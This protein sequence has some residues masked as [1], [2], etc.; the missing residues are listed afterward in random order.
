MARAKVGDRMSFPLRLTAA[1]VCGGGRVG[2]GGES[3]GGGGGGG[4]GKGKKKSGT[5]GGKE[6][7]GGE[8]K[9]AA[10]AD[11]DG[12]AYELAAIL[13]HKGASAHHGHYVAHVA[14]PARGRKE[15]KKKD[16]ENGGEFDW[17]RF[18]DEGVSALEGGPAGRAGA[19][20]HGVA[21]ASSAAAAAAA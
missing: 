1:E 11:E 5:G 19:A 4:K 18:D 21:A 2:E 20:D 10:A 6:E 15:G 9:D 17:W 16:G 7:A 3:G 12:A 14:L 8:K 13:I